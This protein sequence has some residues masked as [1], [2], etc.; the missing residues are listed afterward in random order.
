LAN[1]PERLGFSVREFVDQHGLKP[2]GVSFFRQKWDKD[3][4]AI[5]SEVL[6]EFACQYDSLISWQLT[7]H[8]PRRR[9]G[10]QVRTA[11]EDRHVRQQTSKVRGGLSTMAAIAMQD[12]LNKHIVRAGDRN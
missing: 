7:L 9:S 1:E 11:A 10:A 4:S 8:Q 3:V 12:L 2:A 5:Y 6:G